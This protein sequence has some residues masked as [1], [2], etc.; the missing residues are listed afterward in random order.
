M[1]PKLGLLAASG[2]VSFLLKTLAEWM[3]CLL[4]VRVAGT[5]RIRFNLWLT[6][7]LGFMAQW[8]W[9]W[10]GI[11]RAFPAIAIF[12]AEALAG[13]GA[14]VGAGVETARIQV[15]AANAGDVARAMA[16][17]LICYV[18]MVA[19]RLIGTAAVRLRF[20]RAMRHKTAPQ[21]RLATT[22]Q[23]VLEQTAAAGSPLRGCR[24]WV[25]PGL[26]S[27]ATVG[28]W[29]P[30]V[31][32]PP[33]CETQDASELKAV[34]WHELK[35]VERRDA[36]WNAAV[37]ACRNLLWFHP[38]AHHAILALNAEREL[39]CD[40]AVVREHPQS[41]EVYAT[42]LVRFARI[43]DL[44]TETAASGIEMASGGALLSTRVRSILSETPQASRISRAMRA[45]V[46][47]LLV[48][49]MAAT[50]PTL[51]VL[52]AAEVRVAGLG[53][54][55]PIAVEVPA[56]AQRRAAKSVGVKIKG[57]GTQVVGGTAEPSGL[58]AVALQHDESLAAEHRAAMGI[59]TESTGMD[60][61]SIG[62]KGRISQGV[63]GPVPTHGVAS[64]ATPSWASV[65]MDAAQ[66]MG[67]LMGDHGG[68]DNH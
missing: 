40:A 1:D 52:F 18:A 16:L 66:R 50:V 64:P 43:R 33:M 61:P 29:R 24:L 17:L 35:H 3:V 58:T 22:F 48:G 39:A 7:V 37:R 28:W 10:V 23:E 46:T 12:H 65:A 55:L 6:L 59:L 38:C 51:N 14:A 25:L 20:A 26:A 21:Q 63:S 31:I 57:A 49:V 5:A 4:L 68:D 15:A 67:P 41:R 19:W 56:T 13:G 44:A 54:R 32:V 8:M 27:P 42:C 62:N 47:M 30:S 11:V 53:V 45:A 2:L 34:F 36:L 60:A 9:M